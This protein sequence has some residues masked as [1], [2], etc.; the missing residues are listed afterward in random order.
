MDQYQKAHE[1]TRVDATLT[2]LKKNGFNAEFFATGK[3]AADF[4]LKQA[5][6]YQTV[7][8]AG[9]LTVRDLGLSESLA[10]AG[11]TVYDNWKLKP[12]SPEELAC[13]RQQ[14]LADLFLA[15]SNAITMTGEIVN[16]DG[17]GN[18]INAMTF[19]PKKVMLLV[20]VNKIVPDVDAALDRVEQISAPIRATGLNRKTPCV[21]SGYCMDC[22]SPDRICNITSIIHKKPIFTDLTVVIVGEELGY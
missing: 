19:G 6:E 12:G 14:L 9:T 7:G 8:I 2:A 11:K 16:K 17:C 15:S 21:K 20:G 5:G 18:R 3:E 4:V 10:Q 22:D 13:R 1:K